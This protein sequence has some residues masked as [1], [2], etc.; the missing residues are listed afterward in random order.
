MFRV[1]WLSNTLQVALAF[2]LVTEFGATGPTFR[3]LFGNANERPQALPLV[4]SDLIG[5]A[6]LYALHVRSSL[7]RGRVW[8]AE[9]MLSGMRDQ[10]LALACLRRGLPAHEGRGTDDLPS[11]ITMPLSE[12]LVRSLDIPELKR[13]FATTTHSLLLE[14]EKEDTALAKRLKPLLKALETF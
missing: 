3:L 7:A 4:A 11:E 8:Q 5:W 13:A 6:W 9:F 2:W 1:F 14:I 10:V 12:T